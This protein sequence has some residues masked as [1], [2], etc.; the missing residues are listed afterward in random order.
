[1]I[2]VINK[3]RYGIDAKAKRTLYCS[4]VLPYINYCNVVCA[5]MHHSK[6]DKMYKLRKRV[7]RIIA[8]VG[9]LSHTKS[10]FYKYRILSV[11][12][13]NKLQTGMLLFPRFL[14]DYFTLKSDNHPY[15]TR[16]GSGIHI[17]QPR[18]NY[19][20]FSFH[21]SGPQL[22]NSLPSSEFSNLRQNT[23]TI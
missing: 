17:I 7:I 2:G 1:M 20:K 15:E 21:Y 16:G 14:Q 12:E 3:I 23:N 10:Q 9:Y 8:N 4:L 19:R 11:F 6:L 5:C 22:W 18:T 13:L